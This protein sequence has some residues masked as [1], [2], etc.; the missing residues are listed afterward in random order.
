MK[1][2]KAKKNTIFKY[3]NP[4]KLPEY[5]T[6]SLMN[7]AKETMPLLY[8]VIRGSSR[9]SKVNYLKEKEALIISSFLNTW[10]PRSNFVYRNNVLPCVGGCKGEIINLFQKQGLCSNKET[11]RN[12]LEEVS[13]SFD[14]KVCIWK[15]EILSLGKKRNLLK[16]YLKGLPSPK[17]SEMDISTVLFSN[18]TV[19][20][21]ASSKEDTF[22]GC[23]KLLP[24]DDHN[25][26]EV[27]DIVTAIKDLD[28]VTPPR[29]R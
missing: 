28:D 2:Y 7:E 16:E 26:C 20:G 29:Y 24:L 23:Q 1:E 9:K 19:E 22:H 13:K 4:K 15:N 5:S 11:T 17:D 27:D 21:C 25:M 3:E 12:M 14:Q 10:I 6:E 18:E 8:T